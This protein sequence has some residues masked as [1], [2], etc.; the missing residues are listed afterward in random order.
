MAEWEAIAALSATWDDG[1]LWD[2]IQVL[3]DLA[4]Q[5]P[6]PRGL[7]WHHLVMAVG[8][9]K[10]QRGRRLRPASPVPGSV[11]ADGR[12]DVRGDAFE[13]P[14][15]DGELDVVTREDPDSWERL[16]ENL[17]GAAVATTTTLLA[18][19]WPDHH[20][21]LDWRVLAALIGLSQMTPPM[22]HTPS[23]ATP[24]RGVTPDLSHYPWARAQ[25]QAR[26]SDSCSVTALE[27]GLYVLSQRVRSD[28]TRSWADY[29][30]A[31]IKVLNDGASGA[32]GED[33]AEDT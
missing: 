8:N 23:F 31:F 9:F 32:D 25:L 12:P 17:P 22:V 27:R 1:G 20:F 28:K 24:A 6:A 18:A 10:R 7:E 11:R 21:V 4:W 3:A 14:R 13:Y 19:L 26:T 33:G 30:E 5:Q 2:D 16:E 29:G 15:R